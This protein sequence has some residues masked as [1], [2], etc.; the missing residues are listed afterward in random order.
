M[1][2]MK[3]N[4]FMASF[5]ASVRQSLDNTLAPVYN[6]VQDR[7]ILREF[8]LDD[9][10]RQPFEKQR[11]CIH[12]ATNLL[13]DEGA[14]A[15]I[16][17]ADMGTGK[18]QM[19]T[20][21]AQLCNQEG[22]AQRTLVL[23]PPHLV[24][25]W[26]REILEIVGPTAKVTVLNGPDALV[27]LLQLREMLGTTP[28]DGP[29]FF[30]LGRVRM[31]MGFHWE[32][33]YAT[34]PLSPQSAKAYQGTELADKEAPK[35]CMCPQ[36]GDSAK[37]RIKDELI[38]LTTET[39]PTDRRLNCLTCDSPLWQLQH[40]KQP[41]D[42][43]TQ[44]NEQLQKLP[45]IGPKTANNL[46]SA[47][48]T[49]F[50]HQ[51]MQD[52]FYELI[53]LQKGDGDF[54]F[55]DRQAQR[56]EKA[57]ARMEF[58]LGQGSYQ[59]TEFIKRYLPDQFFGL[60]IVDEGHEYKNFGTAQGQAMHVLC[61]KVSKVLLLTGTLMGGYADDVF[62]LLWRLMP[63]IL[64]SDG[65]KYRH[66]G[67]Q[68][69]AMDWLKQFGCLETVYKTTES[70]LKTANA[71]KSSVN[72]RKR[73]GFSPIAVVKHILPYTVFMRLSDIGENVL[74]H[75]SEFYHDISMDTAL[76]SE[77]QA[78]SAKL[79]AE[80]KAALTK[81]DN[82]LLG[83][84][85]AALM[86]YPD[87]S[88]Q[89]Y[90]VKHPKDRTMVVGHASAVRSNDMADNKADKLIELCLDAKSNGR[91]VLVY[92]TFTNK[93]DTT[94]YL[95]NLLAERGLRTFVMKSS[96]G[97][98][99]REDWIMDKVDKGCDVIIC[100]PE[101][102]KT[103]LDLLEFPT[104]VFMQTGYNVYTLM[105]AR[106]RSYRIGQENDVEIHYLG[107]AGSAQASCLSLMQKKVTVTQSTSGEIPESGLDAI[108][109]DD[110]ESLEVA[111]ARDLVANMKRPSPNAPL[112]QVA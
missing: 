89:S 16:I 103:G 10:Q 75:F 20:C 71:T 39:F 66:G 15:A 60:L 67:L 8:M 27:K 65:F 63:K 7:N 12:A 19:A 97:T 35:R 42:L 70:N 91:R 4:Q 105:Q 14:P 13:I 36:C 11:D 86:A 96:V 109:V 28:H 84:V 61:N 107:Y 47:F 44:I 93:R 110:E 68:R 108:N 79:M 33:A 95:K 46:L 56:L 3:L 25:K 83:A 45:T 77:Y 40:K 49:E 58:G 92:S 52:N 53:N 34:K 21:V 43:K 30:V 106:M 37:V 51:T 112:E 73:P 111:I 26:R 57:F 87:S 78:F 104:I 64:I 88:W 55:S 85:F 2:E 59:P 90:T 81:G 22:I 74:P 72:T 18:T 5:G 62:Y 1:Q 32:P 23:S 41:K 24:Y 48:G 54:Y 76:T 9:I 29:E 31:R 17:N 50:I 69:A 94:G 101:L 102:V 98:E 100:N 82:S 6:G 80:M 99:Q 38:E